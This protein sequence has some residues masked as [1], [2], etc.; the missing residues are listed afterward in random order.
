[1]SCSLCRQFMFSFSSCL[2]VPA[3]ELSQ[4]SNT[5]KTQHIF[6]FPSL[7]EFEW[8]QTGT[9]SRL[10]VRLV[11]GNG[12]CKVG[13]RCALGSCCQCI[14]FVKLQSHKSYNT[15]QSVYK[16]I[17]LLFSFQSVTQRCM[18]DKMASGTTDASIIHVQNSKMRSVSSSS[19][20]ANLG[21]FKLSF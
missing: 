9:D 20:A 12:G 18:F 11:R 14:V 13:Q 4:P 10:G 16:G 21:C 19:F 8:E 6:I 17:T 1:M 3:S 5:I 2:V 15:S 7:L